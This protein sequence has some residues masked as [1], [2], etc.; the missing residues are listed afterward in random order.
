MCPSLCSTRDSCSD[1]LLGYCL[2]KEGSVYTLSL[3]QPLPSSDDASA[4]GNSTLPDSNATMVRSIHPAPSWLPVHTFSRGFLA[5]RLCLLR[6]V[7][8]PV[9]RLD[10]RP[11]AP[12]KPLGR[13]PGKLATNLSI[14][15]SPPDC[16]GRDS[17]LHLFETSLLLSHGMHTPLL[18]PPSG[19]ASPSSQA[20]GPR[21]SHTRNA[22]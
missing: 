21:K 9:Q 20:S 13:A 16:P 2:A 18:T 19:G 22:C 8:G 6:P 14:P 15:D 10:R 3:Y 17:A 7:A 4:G 12:A 5:L 11:V 1:A